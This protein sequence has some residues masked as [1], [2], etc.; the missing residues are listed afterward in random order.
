MDEDA[1]SK[2]KKTVIYFINFK[3]K[4]KP[5]F[6]SSK[7]QSCEIYNKRTSCLKQRKPTTNNT[8]I[9][10]CAVIN[11]IQNINKTKI[12]GIYSCSHSVA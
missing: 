9:V 1:L 3:K 5:F 2:N 12:N 8:S 7:P 10:A 4:K 11:R 6:L